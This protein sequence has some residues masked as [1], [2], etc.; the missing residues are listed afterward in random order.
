MVSDLKLP[1]EFFSLISMSIRR[2]IRDYVLTVVQNFTNFCQNYKENIV[3]KNNKKFVLKLK[4]TEK[5]G[6]SKNHCDNTI[7]IDNNTNDKVDNYSSFQKETSE[8][9]EG[10]L[11]G[12]KLDNEQ[13]V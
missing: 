5:N 12:N 8:T 1:K 6:Y 11:F 3:P 10:F 13:E 7:V 9:T 2:Q 4:N